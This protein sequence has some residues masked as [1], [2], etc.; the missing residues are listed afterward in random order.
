MPRDL[1]Y[2]TQQARDLFNKYG[3]MPTDNFE[4]VGINKKYRVLD[5]V[6]NRYT[7]MSFNT[8]MRRIRLNKESE[9]DPFL[10]SLYAP[11][12]VRNAPITSRLAKY[13]ENFPWEKFKQESP[14]IR[15]L[16][17]RKASD[18]K[19]KALPSNRR[20]IKVKR[21]D[22]EIEDKASLYAIIDTIFAIAKTVYRE[23]KIT[24]SIWYTVDSLN[25]P[26][27]F[28]NMFVINKKSEE[29][30]KEIIKQVWYGMNINK[31]YRKDTDEYILYNLSDWSKI[32]IEFTKTENDPPNRLDQP[33]MAGR[34]R[35]GAKWAWITS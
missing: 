22:N 5:E 29:E 13:T 18:F 6:K 35:A 15:M 33:A 4:F 25:G 20:K 14:E 19:Q 27:E 9:V 3:Y 16:T 11:A 21:L 31:Q 17:M 24:L 30:I 10:H 1:R 32:T 23:Y 28:P 8:F 26:W 2:T 34:R 7:D 12:P